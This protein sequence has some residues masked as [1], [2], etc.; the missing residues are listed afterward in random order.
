[1]KVLPTHEERYRRG[2]HCGWVRGVRG[3]LTG[4]EAWCGGGAKDG[5]LLKFPK[6]GAN[7]IASDVFVEIDWAPACPASDPNCCTGTSCL[8]GMVAV[9]RKRAAQLEVIQA[10]NS[11]SGAAV[12]HF[13]VGIPTASGDVNVTF[14]DW[15]GANRL[16]DGDVEFS[17]ANAASDYQ[18]TLPSPVLGDKDCF[19]GVVPARLGFFHH[20]VIT[21][22][23]TNGRYPT[24]G[25]TLFESAACAIVHTNDGS[26]AHELG[27]N[28]NLHHG[29]YSNASDGNVNC[30]MNYGSV[31]SYPN[32]KSVSPFA[33]GYSIGR[34]T[35]AAVNGYSL[36]EVSGLGVNNSAGI[37]NVFDVGGALNRGF[38]DANFPSGI[39]WN[40][41]GK[42]QVGGVR[43]PANWA[44]TTCS[45]PYLRGNWRMVSRAGAASTAVASAGLPVMTVAEASAA[46][47]QIYAVGPASSPTSPSGRAQLL[48]GSGNASSCQQKGLSPCTI[49]SQR[50]AVD[51]ATT[52]GIKAQSQ[53]AVAGP[54]I[55]YRDGVKNLWYVRKDKATAGWAPPSFLGSDVDGDPSA[56]E[57]NG[58]VKVYAVDSSGFLRR[59]EFDEASG[60]WPVHGIADYWEDGT[61]VQAGFGVGVAHGWIRP[62]IQAVFGI[63]PNRGMVSSDNRMPLEFARNYS[64]TFTQTITVPPHVDPKFHVQLPGYTYTTTVAQDRWQRLLPPAVAAGFAKPGLVYAPFDIASPDDGRFYVTYVRGGTSRQS[65][66][67]SIMFTEGNDQSATASFRRLAWKSDQ[68]T[69]FAD[70]DNQTRDFGFGVG[71]SRFGASVA[72]VATDYFG[73]NYFPAADGIVNADFHDFDDNLLVRHNLACSVHGD[74]CDASP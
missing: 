63:I 52:P 42:I 1:M 18:V 26:F 31:M 49:W 69:P 15:G 56:I 6:Y 3:A 57:V 24:L 36:D 22:D 73:T 10:F 8:P 27:H 32:Q 30:K 54:I 28:F 60:S 64:T 25:T 13:D 62:N 40:M 66:T 17:R 21:D 47:P 72:G 58:R 20:F 2:R 45:S 61:F 68:Q 39:D 11:M 19:T 4:L 12:A 34:F 51:F 5:N 46:S 55:V 65:K 59:W 43:A 14:G 37:L 48:L 33:P 16:S 50:W 29:G 53:L 35:N 44:S 38:R 9:D 67:A 71:L 74:S 70:D 7:P 23:H 41:D